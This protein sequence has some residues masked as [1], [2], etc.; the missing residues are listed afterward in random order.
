MLA[1]IFIKPKRG[2]L[3]PQGKAVLGSLHSL[4]FKNVDDVR[5]GKYIEVKLNTGDKA[6]AH[7]EVQKMC[8]TLLSNKVIEDFNY[9][10]VEG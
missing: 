10:I 9:E 8:D 5:V 3:D 6:Q 2:I 7:S 1:R 4:G